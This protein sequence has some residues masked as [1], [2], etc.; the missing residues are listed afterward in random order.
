MKL[1]RDYRSTIMI[2]IMSYHAYAY[3]VSLLPAVHVL[4]YKYHAHINV[5]GFSRLPE[6]KIKKT[7]DMH[8]QARYTGI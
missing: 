3:A 5:D 1:E 6:K 8:V 2:M 7:A 4:E